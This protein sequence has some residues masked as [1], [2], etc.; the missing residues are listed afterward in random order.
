MHQLTVAQIAQGL[1]EKQFSS[2]E[3]TQHYLD[4]IA[5]HDSRIGA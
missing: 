4:R 2:V 5:S 1:R 3:I